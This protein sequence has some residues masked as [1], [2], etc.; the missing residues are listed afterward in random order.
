MKLIIFKLTILYDTRKCHPQLSE[1]RY[2][3]K[4]NVSVTY[5]LDVSIARVLRK[6]ALLPKMVFL[7]KLR[8]SFGE[9]KEQ[10]KPRNVTSKRIC[11]STRTKVKGFIKTP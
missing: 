2:L 7:A 11:D 5:L 4:S 6:E 1:A 8:F 10:K 9:T 3:L